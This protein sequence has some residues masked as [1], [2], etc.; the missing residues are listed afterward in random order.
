M[1]RALIFDFNGVLADDD[2]IHMEALRQVAKEEGLAFTDAEYLEKY[3]PLN[4][5][6]CFTLLFR[7][8]SIALTAAEVD[9][10]IRR[11]GIYYFRA[12]E[13]KTILFEATPA[14][15]RTAAGRYPLA[16]ASGARKDEIWHILKQAELQDCF[17]AIIA[18]EDVTFGKPHPE[19]F[20]RAHEKLRE[21]DSTLK[22]SDC[23]AIEDSLGGIESAHQAGMRCLAVAHSYG[24]GRLRRANPEWVIDS[25]ADFV[26]WLEKEVSK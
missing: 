3:L 25:L 23:V 10:L 7:E 12:I 1:I 8:Q 24:S 19:P 13:A 14:A 21:R 15:V 11:K 22:A 6:D 18:A 2:P 9:D 20:L 17:A 26:P 16:I 5:R 4:D